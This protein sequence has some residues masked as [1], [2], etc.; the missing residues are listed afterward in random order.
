LQG[1]GD[2]AFSAGEDQLNVIRHWNDSDIVSA[3][4]A[5]LR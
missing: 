2:I 5:M 1:N 3:L 4:T